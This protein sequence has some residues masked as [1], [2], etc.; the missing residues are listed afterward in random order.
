MQIVV[1][2]EK[3]KEKKRKKTSWS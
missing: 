3:K 1:N 2:G